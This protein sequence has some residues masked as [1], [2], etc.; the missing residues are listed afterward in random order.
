MAW[1]SGSWFPSL[2]PVVHIP[3]AF[4][5]NETDPDTGNPVEVV[6]EP[7]IRYAQEIV[8]KGRGSSSD[9]ISAEFVERIAEELIM[10]VD[11]PTVYRS[12][13]QVIVNPELVDG[14]YVSGSGVAYWIDGEPNDQRGGPWAHLFDGFGGV[15]NLKRVT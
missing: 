9:I 15:I 2:Y 8:Q 6:G 3:R 13:D 5:S 1:G 12:Q 7:A 4:D 11:D 10:S 14:E